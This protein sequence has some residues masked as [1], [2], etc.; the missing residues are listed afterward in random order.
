MYGLL[1]LFASLRQNEHGYIDCLLVNLNGWQ[2]LVNCPGRMH[3]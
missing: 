2:M 1:D 3:I